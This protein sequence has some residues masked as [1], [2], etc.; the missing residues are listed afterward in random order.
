MSSPK[1]PMGS[2]WEDPFG[3]N[4]NYCLNRSSLSFP[5]FCL[6]TQKQP[7]FSK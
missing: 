7:C 5:S 4:K 2:P 1:V 6:F 3:E